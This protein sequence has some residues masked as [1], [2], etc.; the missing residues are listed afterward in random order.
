M[1]DVFHWLKILGYTKV[2]VLRE[3]VMN[4]RMV[5]ILFCI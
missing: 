3:L 5:S 1:D 2:C 4:S